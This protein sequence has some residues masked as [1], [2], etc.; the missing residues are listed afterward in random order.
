MLQARQNVHVHYSAMCPVHVR[1]T[2]RYSAKRQQYLVAK[3]TEVWFL[4][5]VQWE[6]VQHAF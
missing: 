3:A 5:I 2:Q 1:S 6:G 4:H